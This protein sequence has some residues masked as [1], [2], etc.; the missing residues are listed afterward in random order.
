VR[1]LIIEPNEIIWREKK[2]ILGKEASMLL[3]RIGAIRF[4]EF[5]LRSRRR[6][7]YYIDLRLAPSYPDVLDTIGDLYV[8]VVKNEIQP[9]WKID[10]IAGVPTAG[11]PVA[12][13]VSQKM[14][15]PLI[16]VRKERKQYGLSKNI[17]GVVNKDDNIL[18]VDDLV[19]TGSSTIQEAEILRGV[20]N[21]EHVAVLVDREQGGSENLGREGLELHC[22]IKITDVFS[23]LKEL[24]A[25]PAKT[26][27][28]VMNYVRAS[29]EASAQ[30][31]VAS[32]TN[33]INNTEPS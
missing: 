3:L 28:T 6:S 21:V 31:V 27:E 8:D 15:I 13:V 5:T 19:T 14:R 32:G 26:Y 20:G 1:V 16:Y 18:L 22:L 12:T 23:Y 11:V 9:R 25:I 29:E 33:R 7:P 2:P 24:N 17:E 30:V 10:R 4:G